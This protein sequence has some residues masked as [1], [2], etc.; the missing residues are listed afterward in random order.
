M[1]KITADR[2]Y[3]VASEPIE[4]G[5][6]IADEQGKILAVEQRSR[7][8]SA[9]LETY[10]GVLVPGFINT[11]CH[12]ELSHMKGKV[13]TGTGLIP[14]ITGVVTQRNAS[15]EA[16]AT[17]IEKAEQE[18]LDGG[19]VALGDISNAPDTFPL[20]AKGR[21]RYYTFLELFDFLQDTGA[22]KTFNDG[23]TVRE[24]LHP[25]P[26]STA[27]MVP[28]A[29]YSV[30][31]S[32]FEKIN[33]YNPASGAT[34]SIHNQETPPEQELFLSKTG[35]F[36]DFYSKFGISLD[37]FEATGQPSI[38]Y[39]LQHLNPANRTLFV[40]NTLTTGADILAA[41]AWSPNVFWASCPNA[42]LYIE[43]RLPDYR[44]FLENNA[45]VTLGTDSLTSNWQLSILE[46]MKTVARYQSYVPFDALLRWATLNGAQALGFDDTL[47]SLEAGKTPGVLLLQGFSPEGKLVAGTQVQR[48]L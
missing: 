36:I 10:S 16:I 41:Q 22:E 26:G 18:M 33:A 34:V 11:H 31:K 1:R 15:P 2:V 13:D 17:A 14:F 12:L 29:P 38:Y 40:H 46:E 20:K 19:I 9:D 37:A 21:M 48:L 25:A 44:V 27:T 3:P 47:G 4:N 28:H 39:A 8:A 32:L 24:K 23:L 30:S 45:R 6:V 42:N 5:V 7:H 35:G 43:N